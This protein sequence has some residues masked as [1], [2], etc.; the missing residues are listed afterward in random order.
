MKELSDSKRKVFLSY[1]FKDSDKFN[2]ISMKLKERGFEVVS[3]CN[4]LNPGDNINDFYMLKNAEC[5]YL[6]LIIAENVS[7][8][9]LKEFEIYI[10]SGR[11]YLYILKKICL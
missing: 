3:D 5:D 10:N 8:H 1:T 2:L 4:Y 6:I 11:K 7:E 9:S